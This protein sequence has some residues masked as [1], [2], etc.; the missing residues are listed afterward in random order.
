[1][2]ST[3]PYG[4]NPAAGET[5]T[6]DDATIYYETYGTGLPLLLLHGNNQSIS[7]FANQ[8]SELSEHYGVIAVDTRGH[9]NSTDESTGQL[10]YEM[11]AADMAR[12]MDNLNLKSMDILGW[13]DG[14]ITGLIM[15]TKYPE[16]VNK[17]AV[18]GANLFPEGLKNIVFADTKESIEELSIVNDERSAGRKR[19]YELM[20]NEPH[21]NFE[22]LHQ[23]QAPV[24]VMAGENDIVLEN[25][26]RQ[27]AENIPHARLKIFNNASHFAPRYKANEFNNEVLLFLGG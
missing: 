26:T 23:I 18:M 15:A 20:L 24:L 6:L 11:F 4:N 17:L 10:T 22:D 27:I 14:G 1:M 19:I 3:L 12:L 5:F 7:A 8:I 25:H 9:G 16:Y 2:T 13:S 21:L